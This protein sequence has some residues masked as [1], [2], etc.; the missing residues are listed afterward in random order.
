[1]VLIAADVTAIKSTSPSAD[2]LAV[3]VPPA[4]RTY[5]DGSAIE[6]IA[7]A[8]S[9]AAAIKATAATAIEAATA[10]VATA[11]ASVRLRWRGRR[12]YQNG[13]GAGHV[14]EQQS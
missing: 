14:D 2:A 8:I 4:A 12:T 11:T 13:R 7:S 3:G 1:L 6:A 9:S 10:A 5:D